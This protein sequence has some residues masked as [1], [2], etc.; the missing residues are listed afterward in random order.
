[1]GNFGSSSTTCHQLYYFWRI[2]EP[3]GSRWS[4]PLPWMFI[5]M[6]V[7]SF[8]QHVIVTGAK[9]VSTQFKTTAKMKFPVSIMPTASMFG[10]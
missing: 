3:L 9:S 6:G 4:S 7:Y 5:G 2:D 10:F 1:M 8:M